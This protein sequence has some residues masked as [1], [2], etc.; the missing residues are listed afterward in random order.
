MVT[1]NSIPLWR[2]IQFT[3]EDE[4][5]KGVFV[6]GQQLPTEAQ[7]ARRFG[8]HRQTIRRAILRLRDKGLVRAEQGRGTFVQDRIVVHFLDRHARI[9]QSSRRQGR[10]SYRS[11]VGARNVRG[12]KR[13]CDALE[14]PLGTIVRRIETLRFIDERPVLVTSHFFPLPRFK[15]IDE[16]IRQ[17]GSV[18]GALEEFGVHDLAHLVTHIAAATP[19]QRD[20]R[21][22]QQPVSRPV[23]RLFNVS[24]DSNNRR[25]QVSVG[26]HASAHIELCVHYDRLLVEG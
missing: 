6:S 8:V 22:L 21:L 26:R 5:A 11:V 18:S 10:E 4:I 20:A 3:L 19:S 23:L 7:L 24:V 14:L 12:S 2:S 15:G 1:G 17:T 9:S 13:I 16:N 25:I